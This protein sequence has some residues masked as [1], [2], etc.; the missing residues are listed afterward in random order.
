MSKTR[1]CEIIKRVRMEWEEGDEGTHP[2]TCGRL[3]TEQKEQRK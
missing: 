1:K 3:E 2:Q